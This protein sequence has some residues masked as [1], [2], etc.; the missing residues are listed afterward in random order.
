MGSLSLLQGIFPTQG[1]NPGFP[2]GRRILYLLSRK[3]PKVIVS[4]AL[5]RYFKLSEILS[6][7]ACNQHERDHVTA[8][9]SALFPSF[10][11]SS[12][13]SDCFDFW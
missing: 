3:V 6:E 2:H 7:T 5:D 4:K 8:S 9:L 1:S 13:I 10:S 12:K 11:V